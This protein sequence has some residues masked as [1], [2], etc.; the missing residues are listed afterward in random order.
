METRSVC[1]ALVALFATTALASAQQNNDSAVKPTPVPAKASGPSE[2]SQS[3][4]LKVCASTKEAPY[5]S[6]DESGFENRIAEILAEEM[7]RTLEYQ[8]VEQPAIYLVR[9]GLD[10]KTCDVIIGVDA[11]DERLL[12]TTPYYRSAY[13]F[14]S[15]ASDDFDG[16]RWQDVGGENIS[17]I[18]HRLYSPAETM[19]KYSGKYEDNLAYLYSLVD[20]KSRRNQ[21]IDVPASRLVQEVRA[22]EADLAIAFAPDVARYVKQSDG[23]LKLT[24]IENDLELQN[25]QTIEL[26]YSQSVGVRPGD[27][28]LLAEIEDAL[29]SS[30]DRIDA[31]LE[32]EGIPMLE[33]GADENDTKSAPNESEKEASSLSEETNTTSVARN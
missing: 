9:D 5:S 15:K 33:I 8:W 1:A 27:D 26:Q 2:T 31:V 10:E 28:Q 23:E 24:A 11:G 3:D 6:A 21:F 7:G 20:F 19:L 29:S 30:K 18:V 12:T 16:T 32:D 4:I 17:R 14:V 13:A 25:G 22:G